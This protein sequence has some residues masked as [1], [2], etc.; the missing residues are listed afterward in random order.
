MKKFKEIEVCPFRISNRHGALHP[1]PL[2]ALCFKTRCPAFVPAKING[3]G[4]IE[5]ELCLRIEQIK[6]D[7]M[8]SPIEKLRDKKYE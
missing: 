4:T 3:D 2:Y 8:K 7:M 1:S 6:R 5:D